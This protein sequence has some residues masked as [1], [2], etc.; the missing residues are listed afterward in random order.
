M[1]PRAAVDQMQRAASGGG[2][3]AL[4][5]GA[6]VAAVVVSVCLEAA[7]PAVQGSGEGGTFHL[8]V[9]PVSARGER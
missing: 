7:V 5:V 6:A 3:P 1:R 4:L 8:D 9:H 2:G